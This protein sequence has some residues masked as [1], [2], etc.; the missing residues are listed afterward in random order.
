MIDEF[1]NR[2]PVIKNAMKLAS[3]FLLLGLA[4]GLGGCTTNYGAVSIRSEPAGVQ[5][6]DME[7]G[8]Y[9]GVTPVRHVWKSKDATRKFMNIRM[10]KEG[11]EDFLSTFWLNL[12]SG[13]AEE[14]AAN[15]QSLDVELKQSAQ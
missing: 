7:D 11:Y 10:H 2:N 8:Y 1:D 3:I 15:A 5:V 9:I 6:Y 13:T 4:L 12:N 14:A